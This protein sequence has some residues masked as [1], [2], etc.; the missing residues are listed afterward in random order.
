LIFGEYGAVLV[1][2]MTKWQRPR[3]SQTGVALYKL[4]SREI[5]SI[6]ERRTK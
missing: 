4:R 1:D 3:L 2:A 5:D 6:S